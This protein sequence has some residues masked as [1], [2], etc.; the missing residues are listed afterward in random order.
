MNYLSTL[1]PA[2]IN[3]ITLAAAAVTLLAALVSVFQMAQAKKQT[4]HLKKVN[5]SLSTRY[6]GR[7][8]RTLQAF[9]DVVESAQEELLIV[10]NFPAQGCFSD[11]A[12]FL[13]YKQAIERKRRLKQFTM[14]TVTLS[15][16][17]RVSKSREQFTITQKDIEHWCSRDESRS[18]LESLL[19]D[20]R[21]VP[22]ADEI[23]PEI[24]FN[25]MEQMDLD[26][27][28]RLFSPPVEHTE[29]ADVMINFWIADG[30]RAVFSFETTSVVGPAFET[31][32]QG[33]IG[34]LKAVFERIKHNH[35]ESN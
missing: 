35:S 1:S 32:D 33:L 29:V 10:C 19:E 16:T 34:G 28:E 27:T 8:P 26:F 25:L 31:Y 30:K 9:I 3:L 21:V 2:V 22:S 5:D 14:R 24:F 20:H 17:T 4:E 18:R 6:I 11:P 15:R 13:L 7:F 23:T 12:R